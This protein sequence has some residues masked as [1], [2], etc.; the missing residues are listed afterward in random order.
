[1]DAYVRAGRLSATEVESIHLHREEISVWTHSADFPEKPCPDQRSERVKLI[2]REMR[3]RVRE[4]IRR[5]GAELE[6]LNL[7]EWAE[8]VAAS[9]GEPEGQPKE[10]GGF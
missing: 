8:S 10:N 6:Q 1:M 2:V 7:K 3:A 9:S 4:L 5:P